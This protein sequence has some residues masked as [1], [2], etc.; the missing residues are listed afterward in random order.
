MHFKAFQV[1]WSFSGT[2]GGS[3]GF[4]EFF[5]S[6]RQVAG[7]FDWVLRGFVPFL[8]SFRVPTGIINKVQRNSGGGRRRFRRLPGIP[9]GFWVA[10]GVFRKVPNCLKQF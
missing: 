2:Q 8:E 1:P 6:L 9:N 7:G 10:S 4:H 3:R 5:G